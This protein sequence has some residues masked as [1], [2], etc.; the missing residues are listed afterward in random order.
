MKIKIIALISMLALMYTTQAQQTTSQTVDITKGWKMIVGDNSAY[1]QPTF[2]DK[3]WKPVSCT[4]K[5]G[6]IT[7]AN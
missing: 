5:V 3:N 7:K 4:D 2:N 1:A 6:K